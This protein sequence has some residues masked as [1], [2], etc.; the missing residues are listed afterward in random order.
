MTAT[1]KTLPVLLR[2]ASYAFRG[3]FLIRPFII[4]VTLGVAG[5]VFSWL[6]EDVPAISSLV[7][8]ILFPSPAD[9]QVAQ[10]IL[11]D[12]ATSIMT[13]VSIVFAILLM[14]L[15]LASTQFSPRILIS[16]IRDRVTQWTLGVFLG[17]F[18]YCIAALP[19]ARSAPRTF[20]PVATVAGAMLLAPV[21]V[22]WLIYF[23]HHIS[24]A[25]SVNHIVDRIARETELVIDALMPEPWRPALAL[26]PA[27]VVPEGLELVIASRRSG[28]IRF[29][30]IPRLRSLALAYRVCLRLQRRVGHFVPEGVA[31]LHVSRGDR[32]TEGRV[33]QLLAAIDIGP[34]RTM[35]QDVEFG[36]V[37]IV[38]IA[39]RALSPAVND[40]TTAISC[41]DQ[42]TC[43]LIRWAGR[44]S[45][46][47]HFFDPPH[48]LRLIVPWIG[49]DGLLDLAFEQ[50]RHYAVADAAV[51]LRLMRALGDLA[52]TISEPMLRR[53]LID[54]GRR[55]LAGCSGRLQ[56]DDFQRL[57]GRLSILKTGMAEEEEKY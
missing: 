2:S 25:I 33:L 18:S 41:V 54:R 32:V 50:I 47:S 28:Y 57:Q 34:T 19:A 55:I 9:P 35:Q 26:P 10:A 46:P 39:L 43:I 17:T 56:E 51:S 16:F 48:V 40:P 14:T 52:S 42:L 53:R 8:G 6:E 7:P 44:T 36:I 21:C 3:G 15:T 22:G 37:Q 4:A 45:P 24:N 23:I 31:L 49:F 38:D 29:I 20:V 11:T 1:P 13:V 5:A 30:D 27:S 12:I